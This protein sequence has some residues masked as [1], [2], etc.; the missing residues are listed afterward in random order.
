MDTLHTIMSASKI[1]RRQKATIEGNTKNAISDKQTNGTSVHSFYR[2][3]R[4]I[5]EKTTIDNFK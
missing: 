1:Q 4:E 5:I 3:I 2:K